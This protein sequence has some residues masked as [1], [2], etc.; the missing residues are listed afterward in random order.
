MFWHGLL[1]WIT[2]VALSALG[3]AAVPIDTPCTSC[4]CFPGEPCW[5]SLAEWARFN[6]SLDGRLIPTVPLGKPCHA[7]FY[8]AGECDSLRAQW[9]APEIQ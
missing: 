5:P 1:L 9:T 2:L 4:R 3:H 7:P 8:R 6:K